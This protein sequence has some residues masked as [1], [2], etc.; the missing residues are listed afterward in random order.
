MMSLPEAKSIIEALL[1]SSS[2]PLSL[3]QIAQVIEEL[4]QSAIRNLVLELQNEYDLLKR[5]F[6][7][8]E[9]ANGF[10]M[11]TRPEYAPWL[12]KFHRKEIAARLSPAAL[13][14]LAIIAYKQ[15]ATKSEVDQVRGVN[16]D[17]AINSL[18]QKRLINISGRRP[19]AGRPLLYVTTPEFLSQFG[20]KNLSDLP[21]MEEIEQIL[22]I[23]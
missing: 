4:S 18:L 17:S 21:S 8:V 22:G 15:P 14:T 3:K 16:S 13:E 5:S 20:L 23:K 19:G 12:E 6:Q 7:L 2:K 1:F 10:Q 9:V 11:C